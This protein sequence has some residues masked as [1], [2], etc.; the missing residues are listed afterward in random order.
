MG[1]C[2]GII[3][4]YSITLLLDVRYYCALFFK[5]KDSTVCDTASS[6]SICFPF[7]LFAQLYSS[8]K[9]FLLTH[10]APQETTTSV[11]HGIPTLL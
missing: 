6:S 11:Q 3:G 1:N 8:F 2:H 10:S 4:D 9:E 7:T 5:K